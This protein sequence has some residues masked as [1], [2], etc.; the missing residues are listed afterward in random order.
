M[1]FLTAGDSGALFDV[2]GTVSNN[3]TWDEYIYFLENGS[4]MNLDGLSFEFQFRKDP[5]STSSDLTLSTADSELVLTDD[6]GAVTSIVCVNVAYTVISGLEGDY[7]ADLVGKDAASKITHWAHGVI[8]FK[9][10]P[11]AF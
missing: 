5:S 9:Q 4:G 8:T 11:I 6:D 10:N 2:S 7:I 1:A 3:A